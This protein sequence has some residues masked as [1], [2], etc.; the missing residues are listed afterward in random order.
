MGMHY[1]AVSATVGMSMLSGEWT[2]GVDVFVPAV[3][4]ENHP[5]ARN[6]S[7]YEGHITKSS[8]LPK[9]CKF[10][11][12]W[13]RDDILWRQSGNSLGCVRVLFGESAAAANRQPPF[14][15]N[16]FA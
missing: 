2:Y 9:F 10:T 6:P 4:A 11:N 15:R 3:I 12:C 13:I 14:S 8:R 5:E 1:G 7:R 16:L